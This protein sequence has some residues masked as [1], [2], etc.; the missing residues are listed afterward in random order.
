MPRKSPF[1]IEL[2]APEAA[3]L[4]RQAGRYT[5]P[6]FEVVRA[7]MILLAAA[8]LGVA[9]VRRE[10]EQRGL[11]GRISDSPVWRWLHEDAI[12]PWQHRCWIFPRD[13]QFRLKAGRILD[14]YA[15]RWQGRAPREDEFVISTDEKTSIQARL[16]IHPSQAPQ[17]SR[18][19]RVAHEYIRGG[20]WAYLAALDVHRPK[21][22]GRCEATTGI[23]PFEWT[24]AHPIVVRPR[25]AG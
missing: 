4:R 14:L 6:Y 5:L 9:E 16:R 18:P 24:T 12:R 20:A 19:M 3:E 25:C 10:V 13:P 2:T 7:K 1:V 15:R 22:F 17:P 23:A 11:V 21:V 8:G